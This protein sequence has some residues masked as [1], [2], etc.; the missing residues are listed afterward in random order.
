MCFE[1]GLQGTAAQDVRIDNQLLIVLH[2]VQSLVEIVTLPDMSPGK[3]MAVNPTDC[4]FPWVTNQQPCVAG[5]TRSMT[6]WFWPRH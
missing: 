5:A 6:C 1:I 4:S 2:N 3:G